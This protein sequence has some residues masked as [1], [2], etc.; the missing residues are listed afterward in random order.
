MSP[1]ALEG[2]ALACV[3]PVTVDAVISSLKIAREVTCEVAPALACVPLVAETLVVT[4]LAATIEPSA[5]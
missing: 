4:E 2:P 1:E 3:S 5:G